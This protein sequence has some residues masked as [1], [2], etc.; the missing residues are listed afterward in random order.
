MSVSMRMKEFRSW[1]KRIFY[2]FI[3]TRTFW[4]AIA[5]VF[6]SLFFA[7][8]KGR[9]EY[10]LRLTGLW[11]QALGIG[12]VAWGIRE[13]R[14]LFGRPSLFSSMFKSIKSFPKYHGRTVYIE[15]KETLSDTFTARG[16]IFSAALSDATIE[17][18]VA[19]IE[20]YIKNI[21]VKIIKIENDI[22]DKTRAQREQ[23]N[24]ERQERT[25]NYHELNTKLEATETGGL[26]ISAMGALW[27]FIGVILST[28]SVEISTFL[29]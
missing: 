14:I 23:L 7:L 1:T 21:H 24:I 27:L 12:T 11:L 3:H 29:K 2:W 18:R 22:D 8:Q 16:H 6:S 5:V 9:H 10:E 20:K 4:I 25:Q 17:E 19:T 13:T 15:A 26:N 28:A